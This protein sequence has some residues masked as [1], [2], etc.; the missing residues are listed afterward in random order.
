[1]NRFNF[2]KHFKSVKFSWKTAK[3]N[4]NLIIREYE[5]K[6]KSLS[7][8]VQRLREE[9]YVI[10]LSLKDAN[11]TTENIDVYLDNDR[12]FQFEINK[13]DVFH[14]YEKIKSA[15]S[16]ENKLIK[17]LVDLYNELNLFEVVFNNGYY[18]KMVISDII[19]NNKNLQNS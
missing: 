12:K 2:R 5:R 7:D 19:H 1:M 17:E 4:P 10:Y 9:K 18:R 14:L 8:S 11:I 6:I 16:Y 3:I 13:F 15:D